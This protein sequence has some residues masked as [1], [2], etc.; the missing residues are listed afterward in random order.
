MEEI[1]NDR[2]RKVK[3]QTKKVYIKTIAA[4]EREDRQLRRHLDV[5]NG[6]QR[7]QC[8]Q[9]QRLIKAA[10]IQ[11]EKQLQ[12]IK[13]LVCY[14]DREENWHDKNIILSCTGNAA[15][16]RKVMDRP[17]AHARKVHRVRDGV[18]AFASETWI[19]K[20]ELASRLQRSV[21]TTQKDR[22]TTWKSAEEIDDSMVVKDSSVLYEV[23]TQAELGRRCSN[24]KEGRRKESMRNLDKDHKGPD[25]L[26]DTVKYTETEVKNFKVSF[27]GIRGQDS[28][29]RRNVSLPDLDE[30]PKLTMERR[31]RKRKQLMLK[32]RKEQLKRDIMEEKLK[33]FSLREIAANSQQREVRYLDSCNSDD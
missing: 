15:K 24:F 11:Q 10:K 33:E 13:S 30:D 9:M 29:K 25:A 23:K 26:E 7:K 18:R 12:R 8:L 1:Y 2:V 16:T 14:V 4:N 22:N 28:K 3:D 20:T 31:R 17:V 19:C 32:K 5:I 6:Q 21:C 27:V